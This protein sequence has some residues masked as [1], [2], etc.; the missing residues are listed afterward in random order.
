MLNFTKGCDEMEKQRRYKG[1]PDAMG[2]E[3]DVEGSWIDVEEN[4]LAWIMFSKQNNDGWQTIKIVANGMAINKANYWFGF[5][6]IT[7]KSNRARDLGVM[8]ENRPGLFNFVT[9]FYGFE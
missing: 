9:E 5:N 4:N 3:W 2:D 1:D 6:T 8:K 7:G